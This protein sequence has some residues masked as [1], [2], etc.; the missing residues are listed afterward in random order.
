MP[1]SASPAHGG[2]RGEVDAVLG[3]A[4]AGSPAAL[5]ALDHVASVGL[6]GLVNILNP[7]LGLLGVFGRI[8]PFVSRT[9]DDELDRRALAAPRRLGPGRPLDALGA[10]APL[11]RP[12]R[13]RAVAR[14]IPAAWMASREAAAVRQCD[15][16]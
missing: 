11:R 10:D 13:A 8:Y 3:D 14:R 16:E 6:A 2:G 1:S 5:S 9:L 12:A 15:D 7:R 4:E